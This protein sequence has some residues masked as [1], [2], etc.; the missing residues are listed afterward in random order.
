MTVFTLAHRCG[1]GA[2]AFVLGACGD[3]PTFNPAA[4]SI[5]V[6]SMTFGDPIEAD[7]YTLSLDSAAGRK[8]G[9]NN[10]V[11]FS[12][13]EAG[14]HT[15]TLAGMATGCAVLGVNPRTVETAAGQTAE[16]QFLV[17]CSAPGTARL[18]IQ[19]FTY[20]IGPDHYRVDLDVGR[21]AEIGANAEVTF[22]AVPAGAVT[23]TLTGGSL[24]GCNT[25]SG[26]NPRT[27]TLREGFQYFS[28]FKIHCST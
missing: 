8:L 5:Y 28:Q 6:T 18:V 11:L 3:P 15:L 16:S 24:E 7:G 12:D 9:P 21:T 17:T 13:L 1:W 10:V 23:I 27:L 22:A 4:A 20:G 19:T 26:L 14:L 25:A 2:L